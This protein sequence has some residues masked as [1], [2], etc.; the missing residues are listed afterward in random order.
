MCIVSFC[1]LAQVEDVDN[2]SGF[3]GTFGFVPSQAGVVHH[4]ATLVARHD[5][6]V[7]FRPNLDNSLVFAQVTLHAPHSSVNHVAP[8]ATPSGFSSP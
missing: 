4:K 6:R 7:V 1:K 8:C 2:L 5:Q 3:V